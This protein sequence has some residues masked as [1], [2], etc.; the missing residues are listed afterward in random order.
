MK[1]VGAPGERRI[2]L[3][4]LPVK[5]DV[6]SGLPEELEI[7][8]RYTDDDPSSVLMKAILLDTVVIPA[9][10]SALNNHK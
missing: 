9:I 5:A 4:D 2:R 10:V 1:A 6:I 7:S 3:T 8:V